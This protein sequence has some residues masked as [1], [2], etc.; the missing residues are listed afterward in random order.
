MKN[1]AI[2]FR[3]YG[4]K[5]NSNTIVVAL[6][7]VIIGFTY[8]ACV[9]S[10]SPGGWTPDSL[11]ALRQVDDSSHISSVKP[12][13]YVLVWRLLTHIGFDSVSA[14]YHFQNV[15]YFFCAAIFSFSVY[16]RSRKSVL[17][18]LFLLYFPPFLGINLSNWNNSLC[19][20]LYCLSV[21]LLIFWLRTN[22]VLPAL[23]SLFTVILAAFLR[24]EACLLLWP[25]LMTIILTRFSGKAFFISKLAVGAI[26]TVVIMISVLNLNY[27]L[28]DRISNGGRENL[29]VHHYAKTLV[30]MS[31]RLNEDLIPSEYKSKKLDALGNDEIMDIYSNYFLKHK[32]YKLGHIV[33]VSY[34]RKHLPAF[35]ESSDQ[36]FKSYPYIYSTTRLYEI[37]WRII[38]RPNATYAL[39]TRSL[40]SYL[41]NTNTAEIDA[42]QSARSDLIS[43]AT[44]KYLSISNSFYGFYIWPYS[45]ISIVLIFH[46]I[47]SLCSDEDAIVNG[48]RSLVGLTFNS[49]FWLLLVSI[50]IL[51]GNIEFRYLVPGIFS[52]VVSVLW[53]DR[54][55]LI[56]ES[57]EAIER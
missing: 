24:W 41:K 18:L 45:F 7:F 25:V 44:G 46:L 33:N 55:L 34:I 11:W 30:Y 47:R 8:A 32:V 3:Q 1:I 2:N 15:F 29:F 17:L 36:I 40:I 57:S 13:W 42:I 21:A 9:F 12:V 14:M 37:F 48:V 20:S 54:T 49:H 39:S 38:H 56:T 5:Q 28:N 16:Y 26:I 27:N 23:A 52:V 6:A 50:G 43:K 10:L 31:A 19:L 51:S 4:K 53:R 35:R 22:N